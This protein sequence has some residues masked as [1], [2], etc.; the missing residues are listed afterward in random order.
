MDELEEL[1]LDFVWLQRQYNAVIKQNR[2]LQQQILEMQYEI[3]KER[4]R[5]N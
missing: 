3:N 1:R 2:E 4:A 5:N